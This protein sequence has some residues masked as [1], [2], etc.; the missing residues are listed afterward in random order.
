MGI[1]GQ[2]LHDPQ[3][4]FAMASD[5]RDKLRLSVMIDY[6]CLTAYSL[7]LALLARRVALRLTP[8]SSRLAW[9]GVPLA[10]LAFVGGAI[11]A[12]ENSALMLLIANADHPTLS[13]PLQL[14]AVV[15]AVCCDVKYFIPIIVLAYG[16]FGWIWSRSP[17]KAR[18]S[19]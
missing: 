16:V 3:L 13:A 4:I 14:A 9:F 12:I 10:W 18:S 8:K 7:A 2:V 19:P 17:E 5:V 15:G 11:D 1:Q 6:A